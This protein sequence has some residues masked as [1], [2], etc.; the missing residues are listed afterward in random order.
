ML[1][2]I[3]GSGLTRFTRLEEA[4]RRQVATPYGDPSAALTFGCSVAG[5]WFFWRVT[6]TNTRFR[7]T[8]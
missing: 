4:E 8:R 3:G 1:A 7:R 2:I 5:R 6:A